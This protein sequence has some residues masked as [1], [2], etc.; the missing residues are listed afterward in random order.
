MR[1]AC[2]T[3][4][5]TAAATRSAYAVL[6]HAGTWQDAGVVGEAAG[7]NAR[8]RWASEVAAGAWVTVDGGLVL[9][10]VKRAEDG[11]GL[12]LRL[13]EPHG[14]RGTATVRP[15]RPVAGARRANLL[16]EPAKEA[17]VRDGAIAVPF[18]PWEIVT[19]R[20]DAR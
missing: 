2:P 20:V 1:R 14:G 15:A 10:T 11:D 13:Y 5:P 3:R 18:R 8:V 12:V 17:V 6:P 16:E 7:F 19:L 9:Q 4:R